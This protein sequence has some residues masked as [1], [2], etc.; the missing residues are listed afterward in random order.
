MSIKLI[1]SKTLLTAFIKV[2]KAPVILF[3]TLLKKLTTESIGCKSPTNLVVISCTISYAIVIA[4]NIVNSVSRSYC[5]YFV[6]VFLIDHYYLRL[7]YILL[8]KYQL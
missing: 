6:I 1:Y 5:H 8:L 2:P 4:L 7:L 3:K